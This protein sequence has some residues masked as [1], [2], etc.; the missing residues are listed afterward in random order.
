MADEF[1]GDRGDQSPR[2]L[3]GRRR[4][5]QAGAGTV[6]SAIALGSASAAASAAARP[7][8]SSRSGSLASSGSQFQV[9]L[10]SPGRPL[11]AA[12][13]VFPA[14]IAPTG[15]GASPTD[16]TFQIV[17]PAGAVAALHLR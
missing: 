3:P 11:S 1:T 13:G 10:T 9:D 2:L 7:S 8:V 4:V 15:A 12:S 16:L 6:A 17:V 14:P 5:L